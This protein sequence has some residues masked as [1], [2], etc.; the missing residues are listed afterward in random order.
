MGENMEERN[1]ELIP[2]GPNEPK[3]YA[4]NFCDKTFSTFMALGGHQNAHKED[5]ARAKEAQNPC[6][7]VPYRG[8]TVKDTFIGLGLGF[9]EPLNSW[10]VEM[11]RKPSSMKDSHK[12][13]LAPAAAAAANGSTSVTPKLTSSKFFG[14]ENFFQSASSNNAPPS[15][16]DVTVKGDDVAEK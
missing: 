2:T 16:N 11:T 4:C 7:T 9:T 3:L 12:G 15:E 10:L 8:V 13:P 5:R 1:R 14:V 6:P